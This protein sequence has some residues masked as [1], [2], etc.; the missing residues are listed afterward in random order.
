MKDEAFFKI[1]NFPR[2]S[3]ET[4][5]QEIHKKCTIY[6]APQIAEGGNFSR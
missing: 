3:C 1:Y 2:T 5:H 4:Q 6:S